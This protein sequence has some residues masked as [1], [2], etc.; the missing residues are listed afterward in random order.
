MLQIG[1]TRLATVSPVPTGSARCCNN[2]Y[3]KGWNIQVNGK[4]VK[5]TLF[6]DCLMGIPLD[7]GNIGNNKVIMEYHLPGAKFGCAVSV[8]SVGILA[9]IW[10]KQKKMVN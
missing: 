10:K 1:R 4:I 9:V 3:D 2:P 5:Q 7:I 8:I 6:A